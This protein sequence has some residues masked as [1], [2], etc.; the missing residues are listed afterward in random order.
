[1]SFFI[2]EVDP[3]DGYFGN[4][5]ERFIGM[6]VEAKDIK[7]DWG[8]GTFSV[9]VGEPPNYKYYFFAVH[10]TYIEEY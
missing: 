4:G 9:A 3:D 10:L 8:D 2:T 7:E 5:H 1:M 6:K